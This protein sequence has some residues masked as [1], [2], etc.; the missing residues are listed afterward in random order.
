MNYLQNKYN[1]LFAGSEKPRCTTA[2]ISI[3]CSVLMSVI[4]FVL[5]LLHI[6]C[7]ICACQLVLT[8]NLELTFTL[9]GRYADSKIFGWDIRCRSA[10]RPDPWPK[11]VI[12]MYYDTTAA[13]LA[14]GHFLSP[15][16]PSGIRFRT[17][18]EIKAVQK[19]LSNSR[20]RHIFLRSI[21]MDSTLDMLMTMRYTNLCFII[22][23]IIIIRYITGWKTERDRDTANFS[24]IVGAERLSVVIVVPRRRQ[25][26]TGVTARHE[27]GHVQPEVVRLRR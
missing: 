7:I 8:N 11:P 9:W 19:A 22:I 3:D 6:E 4:W 14:V 2:W 23:I 10:F 1:I 25:R 17:S 5:L 13:H 15:V 21:S 24:L 12:W 16:L 26:V 27:A 18:S 20:W